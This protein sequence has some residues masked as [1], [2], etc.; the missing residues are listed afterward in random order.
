MNKKINIALLGLLLLV[1]GFIGINRLTKGHYEED[2][3]TTK[4]TELP[5][6]IAP[7]FKVLAHT[8]DS[9]DQS[10]IEGKVYVA[11]FFFSNCPDICPMMSRGLSEVQAAFSTE[12]DLVLLSHSLDAENDDLA[13]LKSYAEN[14]GAVDG[15]WYFARSDE[16]I[17][18][19]LAIKGYKV[20]ARRDPS[21][22]GGIDHGQKLVLVDRNR[23]IFGYYNG[24]SQPKLEQLKKDIRALLNSN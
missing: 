17:V 15:L 2:K 22:P 24:L 12:D 9:I 1:L 23:K 6:N 4:P 7:D 19:D 18:Y 8:G 14:Y 5:S 16:D 20:S 10:L 13:T 21:R 3:K 11:T